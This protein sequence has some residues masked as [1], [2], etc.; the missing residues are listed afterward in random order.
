L[1]GTGSTC[2]PN[3]KQCMNVVRKLIQYLRATCTEHHDGAPD[4]TVDRSTRIE[5]D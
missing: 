4:G 3:H 5:R 2:A 1:H